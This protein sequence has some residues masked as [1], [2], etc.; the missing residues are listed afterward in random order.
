MQ[1]VSIA[2]QR[3]NAKAIIAAYERMM[4]IRYEQ[5]VVSTAQMD[6]SMVSINEESEDG[7][8]E[9]IRQSLMSQ[10][11]TATALAVACCA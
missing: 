6:Q 1:S 7:H 11:A 8:D 9:M 5:Q 4:H 2:I 10:S 3:G